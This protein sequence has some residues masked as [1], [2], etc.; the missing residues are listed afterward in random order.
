MDRDEIK[1]RIDSFER[2]HYRFDLGGIKTPV[3]GEYRINAHEQRRRY[4]FDPLVELFGGSLEGK[5]VL[6]LGCNAGYWSLHA[7]ENGADY[8]L[9]IDG[10]AMH[11]DQANLV[12]EVKD[13]EKGRY[14]F[15]EG[16]IFEFDF[17]EHGRFDIVLC[18]GLMYHVARHVSLME[19]MARVNDDVLVID[20]MLSIA[21]G[22]YL[23]VRSESVDKPL[24]ASEMELVMS[25][26]KQA[27]VDMARA[28]GYDVLV[29]KPRF[30]DYTG[31]RKYRHGRRKAFLCAKK[32]SLDAV[33]HRAE[34]EESPLARA[35]ELAWL[36]LD[37]A[38]INPRK[39]GKGGVAAARD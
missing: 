10:R 34:P 16:N 15:V 13:I 31:A 20:T 19:L 14:D 25:P 33:A 2:W 38:P 35:R 26:T 23:R 3:H 30:T 1:R 7:I 22:S 4:F 8:V 37:S 11:V 21:P 6:D 32:S 27:V 39:L 28:F 12:F 36:A 5:R 29:L 18:L 9:G 17:D 24:N